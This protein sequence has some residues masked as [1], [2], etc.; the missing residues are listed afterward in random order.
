MAA[1]ELIPDRAGDA[2]GVDHLAAPLI[3]NWALSFRCN[4]DCLHCYS[5]LD[6]SLELTTAENIEA[7]RRLAAAGVL[8]ANFGGGEPLLRPDLHEIAR[9]AAGFGLRVSM[10]SNGSLIVPREARALKEAGFASVGISIDSHDAAVH[11]RFRHREGSH[12]AAVAACGYLREA[13]LTV[14]ISAVISRLNHRELRPLMELAAG[15]DVSRLYLHN[16]KC[17][18]KG[19]DNRFELDL[20]PCEWREFYQ[21]ALDLSQGSPPVPLS[22]DDP[23]ISSLGGPVSPGSIKGSTCGKMSLNLRPNGD[24]TPCG[25]LPQVLGN[26]L[27]DDLSAVWESSPV[28]DKLRHKTP[29]GICRSC[30]SYADCLGGCTAR[31]FAV[32][33][34][35]EQP[36]PHCWHE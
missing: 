18:G 3:V 22:F 16:F 34:D 33:G 14:T 15:L 7:A 4:F 23:I 12:E 26:I 35:L 19:L 1:M 2:A 31:A 11:D 5:R 17:S 29:Q 30:L 32:T 27:R 36:D 25:F 24:I 21:A 9:A 28:L 10:N 20:E 6:R 13:G 8:F